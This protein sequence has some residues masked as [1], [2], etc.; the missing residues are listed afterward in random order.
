M[1]KRGGYETEEVEMKFDT[2]FDVILT[3]KVVWRGGEGEEL[4]REV[5]RVSAPTNFKCMV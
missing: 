2:A 1:P 4:A 5:H 3:G